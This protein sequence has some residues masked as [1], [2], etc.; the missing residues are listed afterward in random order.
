LEAGNNALG[1]EAYILFVE[2]VD[3]FVEEVDTFEVEVDSIV[4]EV[5]M[6]NNLS[7]TYYLSLVF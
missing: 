3:T 7:R 4:E 6:L 5:E 1:E 2:E